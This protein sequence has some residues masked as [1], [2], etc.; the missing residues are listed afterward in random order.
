MTPLHW[1]VVK[2][3]KQI[4]ES[5]LKHGADPGAISKFFKTPMSIA[6][7]TNQTDVLQELLAWKMR[8]GDPEQQSA[9]DAL[10]HEMNLTVAQPTLDDQ[11]FEDD[12]AS[13]D[14]VEHKVMPSLASMSSSP[15]QMYSNVAPSIRGINGECQFYILADFVLLYVTLHRILY[16]TSYGKM[17]FRSF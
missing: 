10:I 9:T 14:V 5:L 15:S 12:S 3:H 13:Y 7:E 11:V 6:A 2:R 16:I 8:I 1:A 17:L 4:A